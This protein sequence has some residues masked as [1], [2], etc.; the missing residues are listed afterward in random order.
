MLA[1]FLLGPVHD[2]R[3][4]REAPLN[5]ASQRWGAERFRR[6]FTRA[7]QACVTA[8]IARGE[9][10]HIDNS[11]TRADVSW[12]AI[13]RRHA[14]AVEA[15]NGRDGSTDPAGRGGDPAATKSSARPVCT[16][17]PDASLTKSNKAHR[18]EP[19]CKHHTAVDAEHGVVLDG[20]VTTG[21]VPD[22]RTVEDQ[23]TR[24]AAA[25]GQA[26]RTAAMDASH[27]I[28]RVFAELEKRNIEAV[29]PAKAERAAKMGTIPVRRFKLDARSHLVRCPGGK[30]QYRSHRI[31][32]EGFHGE[33][34]TWDGLARASRRG[35]ANIQIQAYL[36]AAAI[37]PKRLVV[38]YLLALLSA[39]T[40]MI[41]SRRTRPQESVSRRVT[42]P[43][44][45]FSRPVPDLGLLPLQQSA[46][47]VLQQ[48]RGAVS[49]TLGRVR[50]V[51]FARRA[52]EQHR[53]KPAAVLAADRAER[54]DEAEAERLVEAH[55]GQVRAVPDHGDHLP[56][57]ER[58]ALDKQLREQQAPNAPAD[59]VVANIDGIRRVRRRMLWDRVGF[60]LTEALA[61]VVDEVR[62]LGSGA[63]SAAAGWSGA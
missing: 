32:V 27:A 26:I 52:L 54:A 25:A 10:V 57:P 20:A 30:F 63:A 39:F 42:Q 49:L 60:W 4:M 14:D 19:F 22:T 21:A 53:V 15:A 33:A 36:T 13:A 11:L 3:R 58:L 34:E 62:R 5:L 12:D 41:G 1:G 35:R 48:A 18:S 56:H 28:T 45:A 37:N 47:R 55:R 59:G 50:A 2:R 16:T 44:R 8:R 29:I 46:D 17:D 31:R 24:V 23:L 9:I 51:T 6:I 61:H 38:G 40:G 43:S 7:V